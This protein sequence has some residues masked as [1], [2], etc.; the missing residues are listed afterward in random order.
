[1]N[2]LSAA[3]L[4]RL[5]ELHNSMKQVLAVLPADALD[6]SPAQE[7]NSVAVL[8][9]HVCGSERFWIGEKVGGLTIQRDRDAEFVV[10]GIDGAELAAMLDDTLAMARS[11][12]GILSLADLTRPAGA[13]KNGFVYDV[14]WA[15][16]HALEH[17]ALHTGHIEL[18]RQWWE[19][20]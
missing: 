5:E 2:A 3:T 10:R 9:A 11:V 14:A 8:V 6:W 4:H 20:H 13:S 19:N 1:M 17:V 7:V 16:Q 15:L 12:L 18:M